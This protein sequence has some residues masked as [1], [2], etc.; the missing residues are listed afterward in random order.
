M[1]VLDLTDRGG[2]WEA[3]GAK[4]PSYQILPDTNHIAYIKNNLVASIYTVAKCAELLPT[5]DKDKEIIINTNLALEQEWNL[6]NIAKM[7]KQAGNNAALHNI[8]I[9]QIGWDENVVTS[10]DT[11]QKG[12]VRAKNISPLK[13]M[14]DPFAIDL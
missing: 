5:S 14:R 11:I 7:Q 1:Q 6:T 2:L 4:F 8:G 9:T 10:G 12:Q 13:F 3:L